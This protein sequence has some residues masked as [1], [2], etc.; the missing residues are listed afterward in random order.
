MR[1]RAITDMIAK[2]PAQ[3]A[4]RFCE[5]DLET[6]VLDQIMAAMKDAYRT[7]YVAAATDARETIGIMRKELADAGKRHGE[8]TA[9]HAELQRVVGRTVGRGSI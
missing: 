9:A 5:L 6:G 8:L 2:L 4:E 7:G 3:F 1:K